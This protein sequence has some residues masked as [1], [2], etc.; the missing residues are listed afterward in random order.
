MPATTIEDNEVKTSWADQVEEGDAPFP[1]YN[2]VIEGNTKIV[3]ECKY[4]EQGKKIKI[5]RHYKIETRLV[6]KSIAQR[7]AWKKFGFALNDPPG[8]NPANTIC[9]E[10]VF[11][12]YV[13]DKD[14]EKQ[15]DD[16]PLSK[17]KN[18]KLVKCRICA[19]DHWT[20]SCPYKGSVLPPDALLPKDEKPT[21]GVPSA[22]DAEKAKSGKYVPPNLREGG[23]RH[24]ESMQSP[25]ELATVR[26]TNLSEDTRETDL[27][28]LFRNFGNI[29]RIYLAKDK[30]SGQSKGFAFITFHRRDDAS[31][32]I[33]YLNGY[34]YDHLI[35]SVEWA[36]PSS[37]Q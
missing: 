20:T 7:K 29:Q 36:K 1:S 26:V 17:L 18:T 23:N 28:E 35:L 19:S 24:G 12:Q 30:A 9:A 4:N 22:A 5:I 11:M 32:A 6:S 2:E 27:Q 34:G 14:D 10:E 31:K 25:H 16:D 33:H 37:N 13:S 21:T 3:T 8:P 15:M